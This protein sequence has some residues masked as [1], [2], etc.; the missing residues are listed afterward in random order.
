MEH[1][2]VDRGLA[3]ERGRLCKKGHFLAG[4]GTAKEKEGKERLPCRKESN[5]LL[6]K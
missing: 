1:G 2:V 6:V 4:R 5:G 3:G